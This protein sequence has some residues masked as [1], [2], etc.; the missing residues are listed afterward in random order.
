VGHT[1]EG[2]DALGDLVRRFFDFLVG[3]LEEDVDVPV[4][5][6]RDVPVVLVELVV[7]DVRVC[8]I[9]IQRVDDLL[10]FLLVETEWVLA[11]RLCLFASA[12]LGTHCNRP[13]RVSHTYTY[14]C[15]D[16]F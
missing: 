15:I 3:L 9:R 2:L 10:G 4:L 16:I 14:Q 13:L 12:F 5:R 1:P 7:E 11:D 8:E 6:A